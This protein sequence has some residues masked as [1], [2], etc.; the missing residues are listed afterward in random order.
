MLLDDND[1]RCPHCSQ[2]A[3][4]Q[5]PAA[6]FCC[7]GCE[8]ASALLSEA[9]LERYYT[10][11]QGPGLPVGDAASSDHGWLDEVLREAR[12]SACT[13]GCVAAS[14]LDLE[15][16]VQGI[17]CAAC[18]WLIQTLFRRRPGSVHI[19]IDPGLGRLRLTVDEAAFPLRDFLTEIARFGYRS[20]PARRDHDAGADDLLLRL[21]VCTALAMNAMMLSFAFYLGLSTEV[22]PQRH[23]LF[24]WA[25]F[26]LATLSLLVGGPVFF[27]GAVEG[28]KRR[29]LHLDLPIALGLTLA[30]AG[31]AWS[32]AHGR[33]EASWFDTLS[34]FVALMLLGRW[35]QRRIVDRNRR[36]LLADPGIDG[37]RVRRLDADSRLD[38]VPASSV[39]AGDVLL[40]AP[41]ELLPVAG[42]LES[43][44]GALSLAWITG[45]A[46][47]K[48]VAHGARL[49]AGAHN[50]GPEALTAR[51][52]EP[53]DASSLR[54]L[55]RPPAAPT[56]GRGFWHRVSLWWVVGVLV[57]AAL[58]FAWWLPTGASAALDVAVAILVVTCPCAIG[59]A[60]PLAGEI[61]H[62]Q[63]ARRGL[64][65]RR[66]GVLDRLATVKRVIYDKTGTLTLGTLR[67]ANPDAI[68]ALAPRDRDALYQMVA[69]SA[70]PR[71]RAILDAF[72]LRAALPSLDL[73]AIARENP[74][75]GM[76]LIHRSR[77]YTLGRSPTG[78]P[79][80]VA[81][82]REGALLAELELE[83]VLRHDARREVARLAAQ[84]VET[85]IASGDTPE[86]VAA[87]ARSLGV[88]P[89]HARGGLDPEG[90]AALVS[91]LDAQDTLF[92]G[93][94]INDGLAM[95]A[96]WVSATPAIDRPSLPARCDLFV[97]GS[98]TGAL[99]EALVV[100]RRVRAV[101][102]RNLVIATVYNLGGVALAMAGLL[103]PLVCAVAMP[104][105]SLF[106]IGLTAVSLRPSQVPSRRQPRTLP[107]GTWPEAAR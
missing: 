22:D 79:R 25:G 76:S 1:V 16:D 56:S 41:G 19:S 6:P 101:T 106:V 7:R 20:G 27:R 2:E 105:S 34:I 11:R 102:H 87:V 83:E 95:D 59:L 17:H 74:G 51:A 96:A 100:A 52:L 38:I 70:H 48:H 107:L 13:D 45:E 29:V 104:A 57:A 46:D 86:R 33:A 61:A 39:R 36:L 49:P 89:T 24:G 99:A 84:D 43:S 12:E 78:N 65:V 81:L 97:V 44:A 103:T 10:L 55:M 3:D 72:S 73:E 8:A 69:R 80:S 71:S 30:W 15:L 5:G 23:A 42:R 35:L 91:G 82:S 92:I 32:F 63:L 4:P 47:P 94:G 54:T 66:E 50:M 31:M 37:L 58:G 75:R 98:G 67:L 60:T 53:F 9:G 21:G 62:A 64:F 90:K 40:L 88:A 85:W 77:H 18:V 14:H 93:D 28:L 26:G 68:E